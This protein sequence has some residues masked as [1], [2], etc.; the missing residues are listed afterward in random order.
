[1]NLGIRKNVQLIYNGL[2]L[3]YC[4]NYCGYFSYIDFDLCG[5]CDEKQNQ[6]YNSLSWHNTCLSRL[7]EFSK[8]RG[9]LPHSQCWFKKCGVLV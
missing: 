7:L 1:M 2:I 6:Q 9:E 3:Y 4:F 8:R 5:S